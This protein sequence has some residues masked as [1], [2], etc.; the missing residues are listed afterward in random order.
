[1]VILKCL[2]SF[3]PTNG[4]SN[5]SVNVNGYYNLSVNVNGHFGSTNGHSNLMFFN[6]RKVFDDLP[7]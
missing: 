5:L 3:G 7:E 6:A 1:M 2:Q 4:H